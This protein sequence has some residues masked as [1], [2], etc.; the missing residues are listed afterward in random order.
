MNA[1]AYLDASASSWDR[2]LYAFLAEKHR[3]SGSRRTV[4]AY[5][6]MLNEFFGRAGKPPDEGATNAA[7][8]DGRGGSASR[9]RSRGRSRREAARL[10]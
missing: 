5:S 7:S 2:T 1:I 4:D 10:R 8:K 6:R 9:G 3:R